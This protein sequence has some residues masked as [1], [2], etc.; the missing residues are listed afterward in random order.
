MTELVLVFKK[1][2]SDDEINYDTF[3]SCSK[4]E[5][6][7]NKS[8]IDDIFES[9]YSMILPDLQNLYGKGLGWIIDRRS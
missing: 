4:A 3:Y 7:I 9:I 2:K 1:I 5:I 8:D 6:V